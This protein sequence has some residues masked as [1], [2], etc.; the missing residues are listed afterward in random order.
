MDQKSKFNEQFK[1]FKRDN[2][3]DNNDKILGSGDY[4]EVREIKMNGRIY[5]AKIT[6]KIT[7]LVFIE[8][9]VAS[10]I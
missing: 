7:I 5:A 8:T 4:G 6:E 9:F 3:I 2:K 10:L 1:Q